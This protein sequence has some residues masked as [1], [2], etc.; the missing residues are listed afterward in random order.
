MEWNEREGLYRHFEPCMHYSTLVEA[1]IKTTVMNR[2]IRGQK[3]T[4]LPYG[5]GYSYK[6]SCARPG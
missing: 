4:S 6:A 2:S 3:L 5:T 1:V